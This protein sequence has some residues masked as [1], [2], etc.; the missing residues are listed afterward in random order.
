MSDNG[1]RIESDTAAALAE[2]KALQQR[3]E[4]LQ[5]LLS[6]LGEEIVERAKK[7]FASST[8]PDGQ[9]WKA[10]SPVTL[11]REALRLS[12]SKGN[13]RKDGG[14]NARGQKALAGKRPLIG[15]S[16]T[17]SSVGNFWQLSGNALE[18]GNSTVYSAIQQFGGSR[19]QFP[20]L[21]GDIPAR[22]FMPVTG[23]GE[24]YP[25]EEQSILSA[26]NDYIL[27]R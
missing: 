25:A 10:N 9:P 4:S 19:G 17:L 18:I 12:I 7:R 26:I 5:P 1:I 22:P 15:E 8:G 27:D 11:G 24:L 21:W 2:L 14:L 23:T 3:G 16:R 20:H 13:R 6:L